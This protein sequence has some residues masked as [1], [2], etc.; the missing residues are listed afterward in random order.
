MAIRDKD[1]RGEKAIRREEKIL[2]TL[3]STVSKIGQASQFV[4]SNLSGIGPKAVS[5]AAF[6]DAPILQGMANIAGGATKAAAGGAVAGLGFLGKKIAFGATGSKEKFDTSNKG[7]ATIGAVEKVTEA[8]KQEGND[9]ENAI[10]DSTKK[11][12]A[13]EEEARREA[14]KKGA[15][16]AGAGGAIGGVQQEQKE[17]GGGLFGALAGLLAGGGLMGLAGTALSS[18]AGVLGTGILTGAAA[19]LT[20]NAPWEHALTGWLSGT[21]GII[22]SFSTSLDDMAA[23]AGK[24]VN[25]WWKRMVTGPMELVGGKEGKHISD[26]V[27]KSRKAAAA[28]AGEAA[29]RGR[30]FA[31]GEIV[32]DAAKRAGSL[33][34]VAKVAKVLSKAAVPISVAVEGGMAIHDIVQENKKLE[35]GAISEEE[36]EK[37]AAEKATG[38]V[39]AVGGGLLG[40]AKGA[41]LGS[42]LGP[43][44][45]VIGG[46]VGGV[47]GAWLGQK[48]GE[49]VGGAVYGE[50]EGRT[51]EQIAAYETKIA[52]TAKQEAKEEAENQRKRLE[53]HEKAFADKDKK[54]IE[55]NDRS[56]GA[57]RARLKT[58]K[59]RQKMRDEYGTSTL[60]DGDY[61][62]VKG[63]KHHGKRGEGGGPVTR[64]SLGF[65]RAGQ[66]V[67]DDELT[68]EQLAKRKERDRSWAEMGTV[69]EHVVNEKGRMLTGAETDQ[70]IKDQGVNASGITPESAPART[71]ES[72]D[73]A[74]EA[75]NVAAG[76]MAKAASSQ[77]LSAT[78]GA[79][80]GG[81]SSINAGRGTA[82]PNR[83]PLYDV[84]GSIPNF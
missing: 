39:G 81:G 62:M 78:A 73:K 16:G 41:A 18:F 25:S 50:A 42:F 53:R 19:W 33:G 47:A 37:F 67:Y 69:P 30:S 6:K 45:T 26:A 38:A 34:K 17:G 32:D 72:L 57:S 75:M 9:T 76:A 15:A 4:G 36:F 20:A 3:E 22:K 83:T 70:W 23:A 68:E 71:Q 64:D 59:D 27:L 65:S 58:A 55:E 21:R 52:E 43:I 40:A 61:H 84:S 51:P 44:G 48:G 60:P 10:K 79:K 24:G 13:R 11:N 7:P 56:T 31:K 66:P 82:R 46:V 1:P 80:S 8:V 63:V 29:P 74:A 35:E 54:V 5:Q 14:R 2:A 77:E 49:A 28:A 12:K